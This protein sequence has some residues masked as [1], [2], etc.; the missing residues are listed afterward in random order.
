M[1]I[2]NQVDQ[3]VPVKLTTYKGVDTGATS[4]EMSLDINDYQAQFIDTKIPDLVAAV[5]QD[6]L[7][8]VLPQ[9]FWEAG[10]YAE[11]DEVDTVLEAGMYLDNSLAPRA[12]RVMLTNSKANRQMAGSGTL[13]FNPQQTIGDQYKTGL[14]AKNTLGFDWYQTTLMPTQVRGTANTSYVVAAGIATDGGSTLA[15]STGSGTF[16][17][18]DVITIGA[19][20]A[21]HPQTKVSLGYLQQFVVTA[22]SAGGTVTLSVSPNFYLTGSQQNIDALP[23]AAAAVTIN[24]VAATYNSNVAFSKDAFYFV[25][26]DLPNPTGLGVQS[27]QRTW[28]GI[29]MRFMNGFDISQDMFVSRFDIVYGAGVLRPELAVRIL[30][31]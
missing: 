12:D 31:T 6:V 19:V 11:F 18:G 15:V 25:T 10:D 24:G 9:V 1:N 5:E 4:L 2:M 21:V 7:A 17:V 14:M 22:A 27:A 28:K 23:V 3:V 16:K 13:I 29:T 30:N 26:A 8:T 20:N